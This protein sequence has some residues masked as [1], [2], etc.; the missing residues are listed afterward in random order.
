MPEPE[1]KRRRTPAILI[2]ATIALAL[3]IAYVI[4]LGPVHW[5]ATHGYIRDESLFLIE[6][7]YAPLYFAAA[8][9]NAVNKAIKWWL[10]LWD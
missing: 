6:W 8:H 2:A 1:S 3:P 4:S 7:F 9:I 10:L 5:L